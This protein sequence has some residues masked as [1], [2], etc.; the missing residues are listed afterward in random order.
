MK[1]L[2]AIKELR[3]DDPSLEGERLEADR[4]GGRVGSSTNA[5][6]LIFRSNGRARDFGARS[7]ER[8]KDVR[9]VG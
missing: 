2:G 5:I 4:S 7:G 9:L 6:D 3:A 8:S 1:A